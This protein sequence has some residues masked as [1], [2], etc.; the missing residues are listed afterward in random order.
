MERRFGGMRDSLQRGS[1]VYAR[2]FRNVV[3][4]DLSDHANSW[5]RVDSVALTA[6]AS[7]L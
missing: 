5:L 3:W 4:T 7:L 2:A 6:K 1:G